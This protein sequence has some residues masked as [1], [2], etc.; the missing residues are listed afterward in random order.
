MASLKEKLQ[1][2]VE[3]S[4]LIGLASEISAAST[5]LERALKISAA[6]R[7][8]ASKTQTT[9]DEE[10]VELLEAVLRSQEGAALFNYLVDLLGAVAFAEV[11]ELEDE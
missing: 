1:L 2:L 6:L 4:P 11:G 7:W 5:P 10:V 3:W 8:A 9:V